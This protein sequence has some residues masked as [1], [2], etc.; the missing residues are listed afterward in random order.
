[1]NGTVGGGGSGRDGWRVRRP[2]R[3]RWLALAAVTALAAVAPLAAVAGPRDD[4][5][6]GVAVV[7]GEPVDPGTYPFMVALL[8]E[9][10]GN[11]PREQ[12]FCGGTL[13]D[14]DSVLTAAHCAVAAPP[15][16]RLRVVVG[17]TK[18]N[19]DQGEVRQ[20]AGIRR[21]PRYRPYGDQDYDVAVIRLTRPVIGIEPIAL[22]ESDGGKSA[23]VAGWG[24]TRQQPATGTGNPSSFPARLESTSVPILGDSR[25]VSAY[26]GSYTSPLMICAGRENRDSCQG[27]SGGPLFAADNGR[28]R[29]FGIVSFGAGCGAAGYPGVY[30]QLNAGAIT[31]FVRD[32]AG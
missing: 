23:I 2:A 22:A 7:G 10:R 4:G 19:S 24:D 20:V 26:G 18:L 29:Q 14:P 25:C 3:A 8:D 1:M 15:L 11:T 31:S 32:A 17:R 6:A 21:H 13:I 5:D 12:L 9:Q 30:T 28:F 27:D 16:S